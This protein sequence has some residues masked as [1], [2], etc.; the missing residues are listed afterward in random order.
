MITIG[1]KYIEKN[2]TKHYKDVVFT[3]VHK[4]SVSSNRRQC[5]CTYIVPD[6]NAEASTWFSEDEL[7]EYKE[8]VVHKKDVVWIRYLRTGAI[9][10]GTAQVGCKF[11]RIYEELKRETVEYTEGE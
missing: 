4:S 6:R 1:K 11:G 9:M 2:P 5:L 10:C 3:V 8:P 7:V